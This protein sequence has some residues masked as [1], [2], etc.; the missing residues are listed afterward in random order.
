MMTHHEKSYELLVNDVGLL[1]KPGACTM[2]I[3]HI[4]PKGLRPGAE[5][6]DHW[7]VDPQPLYCRQCA[8][9]VNTFIHVFWQLTCQ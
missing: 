4:V 2:V 7:H 3:H 6:L 1:L 5:R 8:C 9:F